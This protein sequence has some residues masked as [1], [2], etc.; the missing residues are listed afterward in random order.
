MSIDEKAK[1]MPE[2]FKKLISL[3]IPKEIAVRV[4]LELEA[5]V[6]YNPG[7]EAPIRRL[8]GEP[9]GMHEKGNTGIDAW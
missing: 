4:Y 1:E 6:A 5:N 3:G 8:F 9:T 7:E 2:S